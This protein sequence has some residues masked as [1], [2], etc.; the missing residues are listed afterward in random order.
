VPSRD[1]K[2]TL[3]DILDNI[4]AAR[5]FVADSSFERFAGDLKT[6]YTI[7]RALEI[8]SEASRR[9][10]DEIRRR[11]PR[12]TGGRWP[13]SAMSIATTMTWWTPA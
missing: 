5:S 8:I 2:Q 11:H 12:S 10:P 6:V 3:Q 4:D 9:L 7:G 13:A 1:P